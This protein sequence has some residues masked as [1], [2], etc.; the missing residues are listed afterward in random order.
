MFASREK[1]K[2][3][4][5]PLVQTYIYNQLNDGST[6]RPSFEN[7]SIHKH[8]FLTASTT[9]FMICSDHVIIR[10]HSW[11]QPNF[12]FR[13]TGV[14]IQKNDDFDRIVAVRQPP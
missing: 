9:V 7:R 3:A 2:L 14:T 6:K 12:N 1:L 4:K 5:I 13:L 8:C 10:L 11:Q